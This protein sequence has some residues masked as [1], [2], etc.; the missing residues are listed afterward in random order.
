MALEPTP[1]L[2]RL[3]RRLAL[4]GVVGAGHLWSLVGSVQ[5]IPRRGSVVS[6]A[7]PTVATFPLAFDPSDWLSTEIY[8]GFYERNEVRLLP[9]LVERGGTAIDIGAHSGYYT[10]LLSELVGPTGKVLAFEPSA[11]ML[12]NLRRTVGELPEHNVVVCPV[13]LGSSAATMTLHNVAGSHS[14]L[15]SLRH[16]AE[17]KGQDVE[18][19]VMRLEDVPEFHALGSATID[20]VK[21]DVEGFEPHVLEGGV[22]ALFDE[23]RIRHA[24]IEVVPDFGPTDWAAILLDRIRADYRGFVIGDRGR[25]VSRPL[26]LPLAPEDVT[27]RHKQ[28]NLL[29]SRVD[30]LGRLEVFTS[31]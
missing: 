25:V 28:F 16:T 29:V 27:A 18:V 1:L 2:H 14:G 26:L 7:H 17:G 19:T 10:A 20:F 12:T 5:P 11:P 23:R 31:S 13:A 21:L 4:G 6:V 3:T 15:A 22:S 9:R 24:V 30:G 8:R